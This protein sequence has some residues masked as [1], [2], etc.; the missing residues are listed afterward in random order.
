MSG[1]FSA[2]LKRFSWIRYCGR[3][4][5]WDV[6]HV[7]SRFVPIKLRFVALTRYRDIGDDR[8]AKNSAGKINASPSFSGRDVLGMRVVNFGGSTRCVFALCLFFFFFFDAGKIYNRGC[9]AIMCECDA[10]AFRGSS[11]TW[12]THLKNEVYGAYFF[13]VYKRGSLMSSVEMYTVFPPVAIF[14][15]FTV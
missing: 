10:L 4:R 7:Q 15:E 3:A 8:A 6:I 12:N 1:R 11:S 5:V 9:N 2:L 14:W 13:A